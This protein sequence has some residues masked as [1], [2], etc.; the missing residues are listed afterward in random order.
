MSYLQECGEIARTLLRKHG[1]HVDAVPVGGIERGPVLTIMSRDAHGYF[2]A[3]DDKPSIEVGGNLADKGEVLFVLLHEYVHAWQYQRGLLC[4][5]D[6][7]PIWQG[8][9]IDP[10]RY[11]PVP[12]GSLECHV[13]YLSMPYEYQ[14]AGTSVKIASKYPFLQRRGYEQDS[15]AHARARPRLLPVRFLF[16]ELRS[17]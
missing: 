7:W 6:G 2:I 4:W 3:E 17:Y 5:K 15:W 10:A 11:T 9:A 13:Q 16:D 14:A 8:V 1:I 12:D